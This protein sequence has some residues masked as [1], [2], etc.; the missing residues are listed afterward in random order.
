MWMAQFFYRS[1]VNKFNIHTYKF[2][3]IFSEP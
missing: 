3:S 2:C 1:I